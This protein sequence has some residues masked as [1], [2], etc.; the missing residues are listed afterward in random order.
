GVEG[1]PDRA[2]DPG[3]HEH[4][5]RGTGSEATGELRARQETIRASPQRTMRAAMPCSAIAAANSM[6]ESTPTPARNCCGSPLSCVVSDSRGLCHARHDKAPPKT[7]M[8]MSAKA[9]QG[10][11]RGT[12]PLPTSA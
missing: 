1:Q 8:M 12:C 2:R 7:A 11:D 9:I 5:R 3:D 10:T 4:R 6:L